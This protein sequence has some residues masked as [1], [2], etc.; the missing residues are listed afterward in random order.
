MR[1][2]TENKTPQL[3]V[4]DDGPRPYW[5]PYVAGLLLGGALLA[6]FLV[7]GAGLGASAVPIRFGAWIESVIAPQHAQ[8]SEFF[9][10]KYL[11]DAHPLRYYLTFM[12]VGTFLGGLLSAVLARRINVCI[13]RGKAFGKVR[14][15]VLALVG[16]ILVGYASALASGCTS[17]Q[18]LTGGALLANGS[19][20]FML[21]VFAGG[22]A[23]AYFVRRQWHD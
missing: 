20:V 21:C 14:R 11:A 12:L 23:V 6:S 3:V 22:Y 13:E 16:G 17:G 7:L 4:S 5:N 1:K 10:G 18:A 15:V 9:G 2:M 19:I 8:S